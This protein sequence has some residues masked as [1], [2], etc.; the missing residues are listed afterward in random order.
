MICQ[1]AAHSDRY[2]VQEDPRYRD[3]QQQLERGGWRENGGVGGGGAGRM[4]RKREG[5]DVKHRASRRT[6]N[7]RRGRVVRE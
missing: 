7:R 6:G 5:G 2:R 4:K 3:T 1:R